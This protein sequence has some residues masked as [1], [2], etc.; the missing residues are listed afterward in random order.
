MT[1]AALALFAGLGA[2]V[3]AVGRMAVRQGYSH[4]SPKLAQALVRF[5]AAL[6]PRPVGRSFLEEWDA[7]L[8][9]AAGE[10]KDPLAWAAFIFLSTP[11]LAARFWT[12]VAVRAWP[13]YRWASLGLLASLA[14]F[15]VG[16]WL[17]VLFVA[18]SGIPYSWTWDRAVET[19]DGR[20]TSIAGRLAQRGSSVGTVGTVLFMA[21]VSITVCGTT[22]VLV[23]HAPIGVL[24]WLVPATT[25]WCFILGVVCGGIHGL[26]VGVRRHAARLRST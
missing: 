13:L 11:V 26:A 16:P 21:A 15:S 10:G 18:A 12:S 7:E 19:G 2:V 22:G 8:A 5:T 4:Y 6:L 24:R 1:R 20:F 9:V 23:L 14:S 25:L 17:G 3:V